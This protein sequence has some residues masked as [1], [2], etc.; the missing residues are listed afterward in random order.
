MRIDISSKVVCPWCYMG[1]RRLERALLQHLR[2]EPAGAGC[3]ESSKEALMAAYTDH[4][5]HQ[6]D[7]CGP[8]GRRV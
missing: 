5:G 6:G 3:R 2:A 1:E 8:D 4:T 7:V